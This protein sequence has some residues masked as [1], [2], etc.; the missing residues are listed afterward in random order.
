MCM[1]YVSYNSTRSTTCAHCS[2]HIIR[3]K[4]VYVRG[5]NGTPRCIV[6][7][8]IVTLQVP[9][10]IHLHYIQAGALLIT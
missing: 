3:Y 10:N 5:D 7:H 8:I 6:C 9:I 1:Y 2:T 4:L